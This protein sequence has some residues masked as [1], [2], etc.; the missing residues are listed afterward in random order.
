MLDYADDPVLRTVEE[1]IANVTYFP[2]DHAEH[3]YLI[4][5]QSGQQY[6]P[7]YDFFANSPSTPP[8]QRIPGQ[9]SAT[10]LMYLTDV[11]DGG[12]TTFP[13]AMPPL[14]FKPKRGDALFWYNVL[15]DGV[16]PDVLTEHAGVPVITGTKWCM[17]K[18]L[19][20]RKSK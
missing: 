18:W 8:D 19:R 3:L 17:T 9:R 5:Y 7:H 12:E 15:P 6:K 20:D 4:R 10:F 13:R 1:R 2:V 16:T 11:E 14:S